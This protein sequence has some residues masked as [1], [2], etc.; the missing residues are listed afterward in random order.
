MKKVEWFVADERS[1]IQRMLAL[2][3]FFIC[4]IIVGM[5]ISPG[6]G[7]LIIGSYNGCR[8]N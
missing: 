5:L 6:D 7:D 1:L 3:M 8:E 4:G 2:A